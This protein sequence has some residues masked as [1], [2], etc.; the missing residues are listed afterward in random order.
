MRKNITLLIS[1]LFLL[2]LS[3]TTVDADT[4]TWLGGNAAWDDPNQWNTGMVPEEED[5]VIIPSGYVRIY[6]NDYALVRS[7][8]IQS[9]GRLYVYDGGKLEISGTVDK[10]ALHN[11]GRVYLYGELAINGLHSSDPFINARAIYNAKQFRTYNGSLIKIKNT[12]DTAIENGNTG[13]FNAR[14]FIYINQVEN[15]AIL[16]NDRFHNS[17]EILI[18]DCGTT[19]TF[20]LVNGDNF[21]NY[22]NGEITIIT[23]TTT[24]GGISNSNQNANLSNSG[25]ILIQ[26]PNV[27]FL[28]LGNVT[29][30]EGANITTEYCE[31]SFWNRGSGWIKNNGNMRSLYF[32][33]IGVYNEAT[34][35]NKGSIHHF[36]F[37]T[38]SFG[39]YNKTAGVIDNYASISFSTFCN[40]EIV[41]QGTLINYAGGHMNTG[42]K[43]QVK[44]SGTFVNDGFLISDYDGSHFIESGGLLLNRGAIDDNHNSFPSNMDNEQVVVARVSGPMFKGEPYPDVLE[45][46]DLNNVTIGDWRTT[47]SGGLV[48]GFYDL[49]TNTFTPYPEATGLSTLYVLIT[50]NDTGIG[51]RFTLEIDAGIISFHDDNNNSSM[52][53]QSEPSTE[54][55]SNDQEVNVFPNPTINDVQIS[56]ELFETE[57]TQIEIFN[58]LGQL[59]QQAQFSKGNHTHTL[60]FSSQLTN[61]IYVLKLS[62][63]EQEVGLQRVQL[64]R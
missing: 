5:D 12:N 8:V 58:T 44:S 59:V 33:S 32:S 13:Y 50:D 57:S 46:E 27:G 6:N 22:S 54:W 48:A 17:G 25:T 11:L 47:P 24:Y 62:Q 9:V 26:D 40:Q 43:I 64:Q 20:A 7:V 35:S 49:V 34:I 21:T 45:L 38:G 36:T 61:G 37:N 1:T 16:N 10:D 51:R 53:G 4:V 18:E 41:V 29:N 19:G 2:T 55:E 23:E 39:I 28:N 63:N 31:Y 56:S 15:T 52:F 14:G 60:S 42:R 3:F 30:D